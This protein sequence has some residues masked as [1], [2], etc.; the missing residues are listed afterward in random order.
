MGEAAPAVIDATFDTEV[1]ASDKPVVVDFWAP[2]CAPCRMVAPV[3][4]EIAAQNSDKIRLFT[5]NTDEN[6]VVAGRY[7]V[8]SLPT[9][10]VF[11]KGELVKTMGA[12]PRPAL[13]RELSD[14]L[15]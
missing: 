3:L 13:V 1:L 5:L 11:V 4:A 9:I 2:W 14:W 10:A 8:V 6:P 12:K 7:G 15:N